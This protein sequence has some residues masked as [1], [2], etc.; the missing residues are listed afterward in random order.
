MKQRIEFVC[1]TSHWLDDPDSIPGGD[2]D[3]FLRR[4]LQT[5]SGPIQPLSK[6]CLELGLKRPK[7]EAI[8]ANL[9]L[10]LGM[11]EAASPT[12]HASIAD[13]LIKSSEECGDE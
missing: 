4:Q 8:Y 10:K 3:F 13:C 5:A 6:G 1:L 9:V 11:C 7:R 12:P 2:K